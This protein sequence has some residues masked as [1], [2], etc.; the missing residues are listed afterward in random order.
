MYN[1]L[2]ALWRGNQADTSETLLFDGLSVNTH[3]TSN[4]AVLLT[5]HHWHSVLVV[6]VPPHLRRLDFCL[7]SVFKK[8]G[9]SYRLIPSTVATW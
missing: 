5:A 4:I 1:E 8:A 3:Q 7:D 2:I 9:L 6:S